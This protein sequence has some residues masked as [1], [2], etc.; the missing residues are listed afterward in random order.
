MSCRMVLCGCLHIRAAFAVHTRSSPPPPSTYNPPDH[1][2][3]ATHQPNTPLP[4][5]CPNTHLPYT[6]PQPSHPQRTIPASEPSSPNPV[7]SIQPCNRIPR[8]VETDSEGSIAISLIS[9][10]YVRLLKWFGESGGGV[11]GSCR[12][13]RVLKIH[14][15]NNQ[16]GGFSIS[17]GYIRPLRWIWEVG[18][19]FH[20]L[21]CR[22]FDKRI[23]Q[24]RERRVTR[25]SRAPSRTLDQTV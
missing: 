13:R 5:R 18:G 2:Q 20:G 11:Q 3:I 12:I 6:T 9:V 21:S 24:P 4:L 8:I 10:G 14:E 17:V 15:S 25:I 23:E 19:C 1:A 7:K 16:I 22:G